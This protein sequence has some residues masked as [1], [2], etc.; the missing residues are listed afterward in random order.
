MS[1]VPGT[2]QRNETEAETGARGKKWGQHGARSRTFDAGFTQTVALRKKVRR[3]RLAECNT[4]GTAID[5]I[6]IG[7]RARGIPPQIHRVSANCVA[8]RLPDLKRSELKGH[9]ARTGRWRS[10][11]GHRRRRRAKKYAD[12][13]VIETA[14]RQRQDS[15]K[16]EEPVRRTNSQDCEHALR[17][18][19]A[20][21]VGFVV[22]T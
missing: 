8:S 21:R 1:W 20:G 11:R 6:P 19:L 7:S 15:E 18:V 2:A 14:T 13:T 3:K 10:A 4:L 22:G 12:S 17:H 16:E 5:F 9:R